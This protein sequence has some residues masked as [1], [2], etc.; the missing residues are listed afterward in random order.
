MFASNFINIFRFDGEIAIPSGL[1]LQWGNDLYNT[2]LKWPPHKPKGTSI[3]RDLNGNGDYEANE[4]ATNTER[5]K[6][7]PFC[8]NKQGNIWM[9]YGFFRYGVQ[10]LDARG[11]PIYSANKIHHTQ[12]APWCEQGGACLLAER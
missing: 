7:G 12:S 4:F 5:V 10:G 1:I 11:N 9:A 6:P 3:L 8:V 2:D